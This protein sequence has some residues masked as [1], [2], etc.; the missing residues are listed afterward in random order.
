[1]LHLDCLTVTGET[2]G[3]RI[4]AAD[5]LGGPRCDPECRRPVPEGGRPRRPVRHPGAARGH[6]EALG[7]GCATVSRGRAGRWSSSRSTISRPGSTI[8]RSTWRP[9]TSWCSR[10][11]GRSGG[12]G[13]PEAGYLPIP[14]KLLRAGVTDMVRISDA[15]MSG[16][17]FG[18][19]VLHVTPEAAAGGP[20]AA[21]RTGD[22]IRLSVKDRPLDLLVAQGELEHRRAPPLPR[23]LPP[24]A[25]TAGSTWTTS[26]R[27]TPAATST[28]SAP[29][30]GLI[31]F[32]SRWRATAPGRCRGT[33]VTS[34]RLRIIPALSGKRHVARLGGRLIQGHA[35][36]PR[37][38][39]PARR[40]G[41]VA[42]RACFTSPSSSWEDRCPSA[43]CSGHL[44]G[45]GL[46][47][48]RN[49]C[50]R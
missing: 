38:A 37:S 5:R 21:V 49:S 46:T 7:R 28:S 30:T 47:D 19:I 48:G 36:G 41:G 2:L 42:C 12:P 13:M 43:P 4:A 23:P 3:E 22:R 34:K 10:T 33:S 18:T 16:T 20:L 9:T 31:R 27:P 8:P 26:S 11:L 6:P 25:A 35:G 40:R 17:A 29:R 32:V 44:E 1:M 50:R 39:D 14:L 24:R 15:R 45:R